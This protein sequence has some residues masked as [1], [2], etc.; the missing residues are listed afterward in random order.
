MVDSLKGRRALVT[1]GASG[2]GRVI[3]ER[4]VE[5]GAHVMVCDVDP[6]ALKEAEAAIGAG[7]A[8]KADVSDEAQVN[9]LFGEV[10]EKLGGLDILVN[11]A[12]ISG[13]TRTVE[14]LSLDD[15]RRTIAVNLDGQFLCAR[16][17]IPLLREAGGGSIVNLSSVGGRFGFP[18]RAAYSTSKWGVIGFTKTLSIE[19]GPLNIR[20]NAIQ[21]GM[22][23]G[24]RVERVMREKAVSVGMSYEAFREQVLHTISLR[25]GV[26]ADDVAA[27]IHFLVS[28]SGKGISGQAIPFDGDQVALGTVS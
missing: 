2:I 11:N 27:T 23:E 12:G 28:D 24:A 9:A 26:T 21:P 1:A 17:A 4:F 15:W 14:E 10:K 22:V 18:K 7:H 8:I 16:N 19:L 20:V 3:A 5:A 25:H 6:A 13:P